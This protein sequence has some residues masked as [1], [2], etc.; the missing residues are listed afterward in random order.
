[1]SHGIFHGHGCRRGLHARAVIQLSF[2][3]SGRYLASIGQDDDHTLCVSDWSKR[4]KVFSSKSD[5]VRPACGIVAA[6][7]PHPCTLPQ[8]KVLALKWID[9]N[10]LV[11]GGVR[12]IWFWDV[13]TKKKRRGA[14][15][16]SLAKGA[17]P[18]FLTFAAFGGG[19]SKVLVSGTNTGHL[20]LWRDRSCSDAIPAHEGYVYALD[21]TPG[22]LVS[23]GS[24]GVVKLWNQSF[25]P[26][27]SYSIREMGTSF[28]PSVRSV[29]WDNGTSRLLVGTL[30]SYTSLPV[31]KP[32]FT[33]LFCRAPKYLSLMLRVAGTSITALWCKATA[34]T[35][36][37][38]W[39]AT[40]PATW[41]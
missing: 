21:A 33:S 27:R 31:F 5:N 9:D 34:R 12:H 16:R 14:I 25:Q 35:S 30:V 17:Q 32:P 24:D 4:A 37:G 7:H 22:G 1:M 15:S 10:T 36:C 8:N 3:P 39:L 2:S 11:T 40:P 41:R 6:A 13:A 28:D 23:G 19:S 18:S 20:M 26:I 38:A 29:T